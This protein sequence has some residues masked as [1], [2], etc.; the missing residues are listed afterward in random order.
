MANNEDITEK[1]FLDS[2]NPNIGIIHKVCNIY[3]T[4]PADRQDVFQEILYQLWKSYKSF[5][6]NSKFSTWMYRVAFNTAIGFVK[7]INK[8]TPNEEINDY[9]LRT[10]TNEDS[11]ETNEKISL[12]YKAIHTLSEMDRA[13]TLLYLGDN[14]YEEMAAI[15]GFTKTNISVRLTRIRKELKEKLKKLFN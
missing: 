3:F 5:S 14:S 10:I 2:V 4:N 1:Q 7:S 6:G 12:L 15:T 9:H 13:I 11:K 8:E